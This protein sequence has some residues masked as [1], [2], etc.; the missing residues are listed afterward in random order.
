MALSARGH[1]RIRRRCAALHA[2]RHGGAGARHQAL[3]PAHRGLPQFHDQAVECLPL[4]RDE[5]LRDRAGLRPDVGHRDAQPLDRARGRQGAA[6]G[7]RGDRNLQVQRGGRR[8]LPLRLEHLLRLVRGAEQAGAA[9]RRWAGQG[10]DPRDDRLRARR[11]PQAPASVH[12]VRHRGAVARDG[13]RRPRTRRPAGAGAL[14]EAH[15]GAP[16]RR[17]KPRSAG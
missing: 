16:T 4:R 2:G 3:D 15:D 1:R 5:P 9:G 10:R 13:G 8:G 14:A 6:R 17:P 11:D 12:A 7:H